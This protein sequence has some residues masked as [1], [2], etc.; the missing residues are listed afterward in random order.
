MLRRLFFALVVRP[1]LLF[2]VGL[3]VRNAK[4]L[5]TRGPA[6]IVANHNSHI[7][8][9]ALMSL[10]SGRRLGHVRPVGASDHFQARGG[11]MS[12]ASRHL[13]GMVAIDRH[14]RERGEDPLVPVLAALDR[15][16]ILILFPEGSRGEPE[17]LQR[18]KK[19]I[20][21][22]AERRPEVPI[23]PV[24]LAGFGKVLPRDEWLPV[25]FFCDVH[26]GA[27]IADRPAGPD[28]RDR[29][30]AAVEGAVMALGVEHQRPDWE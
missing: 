17:R 2:A 24:F 13:I 1:V 4:G 10:Y 11:F 25:P 9:L 18:F 7:D 3:N 27:P 22:L 23:V 21:H 15:G 29:F 28:D 16:D 26:V 20:A 8:T 19:G 14:A 12:W 5:P 30:L 6:L